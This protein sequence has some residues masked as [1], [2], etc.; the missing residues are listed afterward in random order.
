MAN[1]API[2]QTLAI[3]QAESGFTINAKNSGSTASGLAQF[4]N[5]T[6]KWMCID[7]YKLTENIEDKNNPFVQIECLTKALADG[8]ESHWEASEHVWKPLIER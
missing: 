1:G 3:I 6:F 8:K 4:I 5:G 7:L 2:K